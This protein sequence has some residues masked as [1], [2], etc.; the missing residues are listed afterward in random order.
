MKNITKKKSFNNIYFRFVFIFSLFTIYILFVSCSST[1][2]IEKEKPK[3]DEIYIFD[4]IPPEDSYTIEK[5]VNNED[6]YYVVQIG[7]F[8]THERAELFADKSRLKL[9]RGITVSYNE[10]ISLYVVRLQKKFNTQIEAERVRANLWQM[11]DYNDAWIIPIKQ[12]KE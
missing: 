6:L 7:A 5:P 12:K 4:E 11:D 1:E 8:S 9:N 10:E 2:K 3:E